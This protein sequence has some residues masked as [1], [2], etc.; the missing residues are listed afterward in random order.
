M[1]NY[2]FSHIVLGI[3]KFDLSDLKLVERNETDV[4]LTVSL[5]SVTCGF[6]MLTGDQKLDRKAALL[7]EVIKSSKHFDF[8][9]LIN[10]INAVAA[11]TDHQGS[12]F[13]QYI[14][15]HK[16]NTLE[17]TCS[18][19]FLKNLIANRGVEYYGID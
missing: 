16:T 11:F 4:L 19:P 1:L 9:I 15:L 2:L 7:A 13:P 10:S 8:Y 5:N 3:L 14:P 6:I 18:K 12:L 17:L